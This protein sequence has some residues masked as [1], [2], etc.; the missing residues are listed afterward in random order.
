M[1]LI[2]ENEDML[3]K[4]PV[5]LVHGAGFRDKTLGVYYQSYVAT[6]KGY[7]VVKIFCSELIVASAAHGTRNLFIG[8]CQPA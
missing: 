3:L 8:Y 4:Y 6:M 7:T 1:S 5:L 2:K